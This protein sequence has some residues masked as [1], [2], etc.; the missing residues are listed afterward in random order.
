MTR[1]PH[2]QVGVSYAH[3]DPW[4][5]VFEALLFGV[6]AWTVFGNR[7]FFEGEVMERPASRIAQLYGYTVCLI[8]VIVVLVSVRSIADDFITLANPLQPEYGY[9]AQSLGSFE[10]FKATYNEPTDGYVT[11]NGSSPRENPKPSDAELMARYEALRAERISSNIYDA[12]KS[13]VL[14]GLLL[15]IAVVLFIVHWRWLRTL[16]P[17]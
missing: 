14:D 10:A 11:E 1:L 16:S 17:T 15:V 12:K 13:L 6:V 5:F 8:A 2:E 9:G 7:Y 4:I 3:T